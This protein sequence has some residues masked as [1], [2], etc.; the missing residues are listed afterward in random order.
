MDSCRH[1]GVS[2]GDSNWAEHRRTRKKQDRIC[3]SCYNTKAREYSKRA[4]EKRKIYRSRNVNTTLLSGAKSR[5]NRKGLEFNLEIDDIIIPEKCPVFGVP[6]ERAEG[7]CPDDNSP[8]LDR[9]D[10]SKGYV[11][12]NVQVISWK[13]NRLKSNGTLEDFRAIVSWLEGVTS[14]ETL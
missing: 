4:S 12:G 10:S 3:T 13:A 9:L 2:L 11:K 8:T 7:G 6:L 5:A 1:C 14:G